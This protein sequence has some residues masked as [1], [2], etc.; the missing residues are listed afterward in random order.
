MENYLVT[1]HEFK[2]GLIFHEVRD[3]DGKTKSIAYNAIR[4]GLSWPT[5]ENP[6]SYYCILGDQSRG[7]QF[8][9]VV[10]P[11]AKLRFLEEK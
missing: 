7:T 8:Q 10:Q 11:P 9:G 5:A 3:D 4:A 2:D 6:K 1:K